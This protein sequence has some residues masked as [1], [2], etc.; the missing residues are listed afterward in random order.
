MQIPILKTKKQVRE[1]RRAVGYCCLWILGF[2]EITKPLYTC[3]GGKTEKLNWTEIEIKA[4]Q[5]L[6]QACQR[7]SV[8]TARP[9]KAISVTCGRGSG[10][11]KGGAN[12]IPR[13]MEK[14]CGILIQAA[15]H[16]GCRVA[17]V[18]KSSSSYSYIGK[19]SLETHPQAGLASSGSTFR[20]GTVAKHTGALAL[21]CSD[22]PVSDTLA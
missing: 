10:N 2:A 12:P 6:K 7:T 19:G 17:G 11:H 1:F 5:D 13:T 14:A 22:Q 15:R 9:H 8:S 3:T 16:H 4:F 20:G 18:F 21:E